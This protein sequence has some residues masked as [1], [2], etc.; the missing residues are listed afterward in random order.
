MAAAPAC[1]RGGAGAGDAAA[2]AGIEWA[3]VLG[4]DGQATAR[5]VAA[6]ASGGAV[7]VGGFDGVLEVG[8][9]RLTSA[10]ASDGFAIAVDA[11]GRPF[12]RQALAGPLGNELSTVATAAGG[13]I[14]VAGFAAPGASLGEREIR[15]AGEPIAIVARLDEAGRPAWVRT[16]SASGYAVTTAVAWTPEGDVVAA[17]YHGGTLEPDGAALHS[18]GALDL[19]VARLRGSDGAIVWLHR[20]GGPG[21]DAAYALAVSDAGGIAVAGSLSAWADLSSNRLVAVAGVDPFVAGVDQTGFRWARSLPSA[22]SGIGKQLAAL[23]GGDLAVAIEFDGDLLVEDRPLSAA[24]PGDIVLARLAP[25][26][27]I[28]WTQQLAGPGA[29]SVAGLALAGSRL[30]V[31]G[32]FDDRLAIGGAPLLRGSDRDGVLAT[33][34]LQGKPLRQ[35]TLGGKGDQSIT[36]LAAAGPRAFLAGSATTRLPAPLTGDV[37]GASDAFLLKLVP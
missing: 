19:W 12:W 13:R 5:G 6:L 29:D 8:Q 22:G 15:G 14:A 9:A 4:G 20:A 1:R 26:G 25:A 16:L 37:A 28:R 34:D 23:P 31:A 3:L 7:L 32:G 27:A 17:G 11:G 2:G 33:F 10:G 30:L 24:G 36:S 35:R 21:P 18:A